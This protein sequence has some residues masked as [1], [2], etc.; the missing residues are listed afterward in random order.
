MVNRRHLLI[1][2]KDDLLPAIFKFFKFLWMLPFHDNFWEEVKNSKRGKRI[3]AIGEKDIFKDV[4]MIKR[5][6]DISSFDEEDKKHILY[7]ID[8]MINNVKL[9]NITK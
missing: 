6:K 7:A 1:P 2:L 9:K 5:L 3:I 8:A 4:K